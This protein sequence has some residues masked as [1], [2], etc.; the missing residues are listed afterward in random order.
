MTIEKFVCNECGYKFRTVKAAE[1]AAFGERGCPGCGGADID[2]APVE[3]KALIAQV[4][5]ALAERAAKRAAARELRIAHID[6]Q[7]DA[8]SHRVAKGPSQ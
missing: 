5:A 2:L 7:L 8:L 1:R 4:D 3:R 6:E